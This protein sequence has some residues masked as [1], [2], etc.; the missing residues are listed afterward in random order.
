M[1]CAATLSQMTPKPVTA[2]TASLALLIDDI[3]PVIVSVELVPFDQPGIVLASGLCYNV[4][5]R[6]ADFAPSGLHRYS[7]S[8]TGRVRD[9]RVGAGKGKGLEWAGW[10]AEPR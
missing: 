8:V 4:L 5:V 2:G 10:D 9:Q 3:D 1:A 6:L 7:S